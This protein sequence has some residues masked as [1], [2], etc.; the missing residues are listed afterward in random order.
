MEFKFAHEKSVG[1]S[2][3]PKAWSKLHK[4]L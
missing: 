4:C 3:A 2:G 1:S